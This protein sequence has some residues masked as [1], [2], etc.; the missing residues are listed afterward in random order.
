M[1]AA[2]A[3]GGFVASPFVPLVADK[4]GRRYS[5][6]LGSM[7]SIIGVILQGSAV[8]GKWSVVCRVPNVRKLI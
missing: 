2:F 1:V 7:V 6:L 8:N 5:M 4:L 3:I